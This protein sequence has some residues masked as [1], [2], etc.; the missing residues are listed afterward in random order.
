MK[1]RE[2]LDVAGA[3]LG[4]RGDSL[5]P[6][7]LEPVRVAEVA[8]RVVR[9]DQHALLLGNALRLLEDV[10]VELASSAR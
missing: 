3:G 2:L 6:A 7:H 4:R 5:Q 8:E 9:G 1:R 10:G